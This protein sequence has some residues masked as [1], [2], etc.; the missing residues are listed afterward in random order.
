LRRLLITGAS[1]FIGTNLC[2]HFLARGWEVYGLVR[3]TSDTHSLNGVDVKL[4]VGD[5]QD[6]ASFRIPADVEAIIHTAS[7]V[8]DMADD[9]TCRRNIYDL[10]V[11]LA[12][13]IEEMPRPP[14]RLLH[15]STALVLGF[16]ARDISE[17]KPGKPAL[18]LAYTRYKVK[19]EEFL[20]DR[21]RTRGL[22]LVILRPGDVYGPHDR[23]SS[24][25][26]L[27]A[28]DEGMPLIIGGGHHQFPF[29]YSGNLCQA[30][31]LALEKAG[32]EGRTYTVTNSVLPTWRE[33]FTGLQNG[34]G[35][36]Q[37]VYVPVW[38]TFAAAGLLKGVHKLQR[39]FEPRITYYR[40]KRVIT[41]TTYDISKT[42]QDLGYR[43]D[44]RMD[45]QVREIVNWYK[46]E[47]EDGLIR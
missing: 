9:E 44:D 20:L 37:R 18:F 14:K 41:E 43:P 29:C 2:R 32:I 38:L 36:K 11:N 4:I 12:R 28:C 5:L 31:E 39:G 6:P 46:K 15:I 1:G 17:G 26:M 13:K 19:T 35:K 33:F 22:P 10:A 34:L 16:G 47:K 24:A 25:K 27:R 30:A 3:K 42:I 7:T 8:S 23:V 40:I 21:W 45:I